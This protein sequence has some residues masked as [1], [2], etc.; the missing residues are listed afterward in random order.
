MNP[1]RSVV[2]GALGRYLKLNLRADNT[3]A[4][5]VFLDPPGRPKREVKFLSLFIFLHFYVLG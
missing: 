4:V 2:S 1:S 5:T 3:S